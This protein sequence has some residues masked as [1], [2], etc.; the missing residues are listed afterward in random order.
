MGIAR[1]G[2]KKTQC[3]ASITVRDAMSPL[4]PVTQRMIQEGMTH[5][6]VRTS[7]DW[8]GL[9]WTDWDREIKR[10]RETVEWLA[11]WWLQSEQNSVHSCY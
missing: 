3:T 10:N 8:C 2:P 7:V 6:A 4:S 1:I 5:W 11:R 9:V